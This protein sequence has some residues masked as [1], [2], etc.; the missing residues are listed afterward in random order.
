MAKPKTAVEPLAQKAYEPSKRETAALERFANL[1]H[2]AGREHLADEYFTRASNIR[3][4]HSHA[5]FV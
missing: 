2:E 3:D 5:L 4:R 1:F